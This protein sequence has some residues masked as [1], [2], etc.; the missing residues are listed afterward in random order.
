MTAAPATGARVVG[1]DYR[2]RVPTGWRDYTKQLDDDRVDRAAASVRGSRSSVNVV[3][4]DQSITSGQLDAVLET[5]R[6]KI[7]PSAPAY[8]I[9]PEV[10]VA[11]A[12]AGHLGGLRTQD[13]TKYWLEQYVFGHGAH[14]Y[15]VSFSFPPKV[16]AAARARTIGAILASWRWR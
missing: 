7:L 3:L 15:I 10:T 13:R 11:G 16:R 12:R 4:T 6:D 2:F 14:T 8:E 1:D 5:I 9:L